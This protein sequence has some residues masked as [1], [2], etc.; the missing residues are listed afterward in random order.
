MQR[1]SVCLSVCPSLCLFNRMCPR[2][3]GSFSHC[4]LALRVALSSFRIALSRLAFQPRR[5]ALR[6][7]ASRCNLEFS[8]CTLAILQSRARSF[9][10]NRD[11]PSRP[12][13]ICDPTRHQNGPYVLYVMLLSLLLKSMVSACIFIFV[14][15]SIC[16]YGQIHPRER[17]GLSIFWVLFVIRFR[18]SDTIEL[19]QRKC[20]RVNLSNISYFP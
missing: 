12:P 15:L 16:V 1:L 9:S 10:G 3:N 14:Y 11:G 8:L 18:F 6:S 5:F 20:I 19:I 2:V 17:F 7:R 4:N 13:Y